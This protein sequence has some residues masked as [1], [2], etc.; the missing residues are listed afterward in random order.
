MNVFIE[1]G[2]NDAEVHALIRRKYGDQARVMSR[3]EYKEGG[4]LGMFAKRVVE[5]SGYTQQT[6]FSK[7]KQQQAT[8]FQTNKAKLLQTIKEQ[9]RE[10]TYKEILDEV[11]SLR[12]ELKHGVG[13]VQASADL[14][15][16][17]VRLRKILRENEFTESVIAKIEAMVQRFSLEDLENHRMID[18]CVFRWLADAIV[19]RADITEQQKP[20]TILIGPTGVGKTTTIAKLAALY[21]MKYKHLENIRLVT[22]DNY[23]IGAVEQIKTYGK[24]MNIPVFTTDSSEELQKIISLQD[25]ETVLF[26]DTIGKSPN[27]FQHLGSMR[28]VLE[29]CIATAHTMLCISATTKISDAHEIIRQYD[30]FNIGSIIFTKLDET[31]HVGEVIS[32]LI[33]SQ[34]ALSHVTTGQKV[35]S[36]IL[37]GGT[38]KLLERLHGFSLHR[39][40]IQSILEEADIN[41]Q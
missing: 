38:I 6:V 40:E 13:T 34:K 16:S 33:E 12:N 9:P 27:D 31:S 10:D 25:A 26:I 8:N 18:L 17:I 3:R 11:K 15:S 5:I 19:E 32:L 28:S 20:I 21:G 29:A 37:E 35:P 1:R 4:F 24:I 36:D 14:H 39:E 2:R 23:R 41:V 22:I 7:S 30:I